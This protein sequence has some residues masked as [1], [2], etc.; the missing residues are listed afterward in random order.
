MGLDQIRARSL[1]FRGC[2]VTAFF[3]SLSLD[4]SCKFLDSFK[5][6]FCAEFTMNTFDST[7]SNVFFH[8]PSPS[9]LQRQMSMPSPHPRPLSPNSYIRIAY[10]PQWPT[11]WTHLVSSELASQSTVKP[12]NDQPSLRN[13]NSWNTVT[14]LADFAQPDN[15]DHLHDIGS[16]VSL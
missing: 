12:S 1:E 16:Q 11:S 10:L 9:L 3:L 7:T 13:S 2:Y 15:T 4:L 6:Y 5:N 8:P 14:S